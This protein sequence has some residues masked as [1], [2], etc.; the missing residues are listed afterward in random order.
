MNKFFDVIIPTRNDY[1]YL[2]SI[3]NVLFSCDKIDRVFVVDN[4]SEFG[5]SSEIKNICSSFDSC[6]YLEC[7]NPG[8]GNAVRMGLE[9][10]ENDVLFI[11]A[12]IENFCLD[13]FLPLIL[14]IEEGYG[15]V[16]ASFL[17]KNG[18][19]NS[20]F[21]LNKLLELYPDLNIS[22]PTGG[23]YVVRKNV[24]D[25]FVLP[26]FWNIDLSIL[27]QAYR[28]GFLITEVFIGVLVDKARDAES[29]D[30]S[31]ECLLAEVEGGMIL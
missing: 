2:E 3:L 1:L 22:R 24:L 21:V 29:L 31:R 25:S 4:C 26:S 19:S 6:S 18:Q 14:K 17:R 12:D 27:L 15:L 13:F 16:K 28:N 7:L 23:I 11:D 10:V 20:S 9:Y 30:F 5:I 8:K